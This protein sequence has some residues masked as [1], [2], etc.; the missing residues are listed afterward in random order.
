MN[1]ERITASH[2]NK[3]LWVSDDTGFCVGRFSKAFGMDVH[4]SFDDMIDS[5]IQ[6]LNC[7]HERPDQSDFF[8]FCDLILAYFRIEVDKS[9]LEF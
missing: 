1:D 5:G 4:N 6:C 9:I 3:T 7:T 8:E 2:D